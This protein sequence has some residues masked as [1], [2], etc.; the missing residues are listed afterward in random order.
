MA[1]LNIAAGLPFGNFGI[2]GIILVALFF[3]AC[4]CTFFSKNKAV[5]RASFIYI[6]VI[7]VITTS[8]IIYLLVTGTPLLDFLYGTGTQP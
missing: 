7:F 2:V 6:A 3:V 5:L 1:L 8:I 4:F